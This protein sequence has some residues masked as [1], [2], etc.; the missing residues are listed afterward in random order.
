MKD[1]GDRGNS[2]G[3]SG[4]TRDFTIKFGTGEKGMRECAIRQSKF[5]GTFDGI[6]D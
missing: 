1:K 6:R 3:S 5:R 4:V 2:L